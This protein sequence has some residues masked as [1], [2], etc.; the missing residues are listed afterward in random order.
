MKMRNLIYSL[1]IALMLLAQAV[2][3]QAIPV[4]GTFT[5]TVNGI[6]G[7][8]TVSGVFTPATKPV[9]PPVVTPPAT[10]PVD[11]PVVIV[12][13]PTTD[14]T[15]LP[16][17]PPGRPTKATTGIK[18]GTVLKDGSK[19]KIAAGGTYDG[20]AFGSTKAILAK[21]QTATFT[22]CR[23]DGSTYGINCNGNLGQITVDHCEFVNQSSA[24]IY[25]DGFT[26]TNSYVHKSA[27]DG[28]KPGQNVTIQGNYVEDLGF[29]SPAAHADGVQIR[30]GQNIRI[31]GNTFNIL[32]GKSSDG[33][34]TIKGNSAVFVQTSS[35][36]ACA[37][38]EVSGNWIN[39]AN[40]GIHA[41]PSDSATSS[42]L[43][44]IA[45]NTIDAKAGLEIGAGSGVKVS[46]N[47]HSNATAI[48]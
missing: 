22:N 33:S 23:F 8:A 15:T 2:H 37:G 28:F 3:G 34:G 17:P 40:S 38:I 9:D 42:T 48:K 39:C 45:G 5:G 21:G 41:Y 30:G 20:Y 36:K 4:S 7:T 24:G 10:V 27:G 12:T 32:A 44:T 26:C 11:P 16:I 35:G 18:P 29:N 47:V 31:I 43:M 19:V 14:P 1:A 25:G 6:A 13:P 46:L